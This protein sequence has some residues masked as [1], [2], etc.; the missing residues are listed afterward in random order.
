MLDAV[1]LGFRLARL[2]REAGLS[3]AELA[4]R[5]GT[6]QSVVSRMEAGRSLPSLALIDRLVAATG[7]PFSISFGAAG[8]EPSTEVRRARLRR[9]L[10]TYVFN[11]WDRDPTDAEARSLVADG[12]TREQFEGANPPS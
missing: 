7:R 6:T 4:S 11:P 9:V 10:G 5:M 3:Q 2:R 12:L 1:Q 8:S